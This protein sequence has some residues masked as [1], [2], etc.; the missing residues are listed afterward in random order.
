LQS[1]PFYKMKSNGEFDLTQ[2]ITT[3]EDAKNHP[4]VGYLT[5]MF[6]KK[7]IE[8]L[9]QFANTVT[10]NGRMKPD[11]NRLRAHIEETCLQQCF[12]DSVYVL[13]NTFNISDAHNGVIEGTNEISKIKCKTSIL[14]GEK[15]IAVPFKEQE[16]IKAALGDLATLKG[17]EDSGHAVFEDHL[18]E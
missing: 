8:G 7:D 17:F 16:K 4:S 12:A 14:C 11:Q 10:Y 2:R 5:S 15:D 18:E 1:V 3:Y 6:E 9:I 13:N